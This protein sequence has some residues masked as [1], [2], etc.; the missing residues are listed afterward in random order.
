M[1]AYIFLYSLQLFL[2][3]KDKNESGVTLSGEV[4]KDSFYKKNKY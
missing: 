3:P 2:T 4:I 1:N